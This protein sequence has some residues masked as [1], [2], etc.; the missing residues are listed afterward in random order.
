[1]KPSTFFFLLFLLASVVGLRAQEVQ[2]GPVG[3]SSTLVIAVRLMPIPG[4]PLSGKSE[5]EWKK[6]LPNGNTVFVHAASILARDSEGRVYRERHQFVPMD[7]DP[8][9]RWTEI[10]IFDPVKHA[11]TVC[12]LQTK[13]CEVT[14]YYPEKHFTLAAAGWNEEHTSFVERE[15]LGKDQLLGMEVLRSRETV[16]VNAGV[17]NNDHPIVTQSEYWYSAALQT[18]LM[19]LRVDPKTGTQMVRM[20]ELNVGDPDPEFFMV[21]EGFVVEDKRGASEA[22]KQKPTGSATGSTGVR[23][24]YNGKD[25][26]TPV[27]AESTEE[28]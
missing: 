13:H 15:S 12:I 28:Q 17:K 14:S 22:P 9:S 21:P 16:I 25:V 4:A 18:N 19:I 5:V 11:Q 26:P 27:P 1:M 8:M 7:V 6:K 10:E 20:Y 24:A 23:P 3:G 2:R